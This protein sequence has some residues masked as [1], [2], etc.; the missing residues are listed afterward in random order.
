MLDWLFTEILS[1][2]QLILF[3][4]GQASSYYQIALISSKK[5]PVN[6]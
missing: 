5:D 3:S 4:F 6:I 1:S 2:S